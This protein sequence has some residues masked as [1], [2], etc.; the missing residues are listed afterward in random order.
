MAEAL[1]KRERYVEAINFWHKVELARPDDE[2]PKRSI[3]TITVLQHQAKDPKYEADKKTAGKSGAGK[4]EE[5]THEDRLKQRIQRNPKDLTGYDELGNL[6]LNTDRFAEAEEVFKQKLAA[7]N[8]DPTVREEIED[9]QLRALRSKMIEG[10]KKAK[11]SGNEADKKE[12]RAAPH[13]RHREGTGSLS[14]PLRTLSEQSHLPLRTGPAVPVERRHRRGDQGISGR[15]GRPAQEGN[16]PD[17]SGRVFP[18][19]Q[20]VIIWR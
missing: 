9:V 12:Y 15:Q 2:L 14:E 6:Y 4:Q 19:D 7:S 13:D 20:A 5:F 18:G 17:Q 10:G 16:V 1:T 3:A 8:N 11:E